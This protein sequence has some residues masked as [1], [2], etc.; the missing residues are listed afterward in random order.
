MK[1]FI[2]IILLSSVCFA[3]QLR[4]RVLNARNQQPL[5]KQTVT[6]QYLSEK[7]PSASSPLRLETDNR[8]EARFTLPNPVPTS[9]N[10]KVSLTSEHWHCGCWVM[11]DTAQVLRNGVAQPPSSKRAKKTETVRAEP[12]EVVILARPLTF[13]ERLLY[14][15]LKQ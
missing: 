12:G 9:V 11:A 1:A 2:W 8:G 10:I 5:E 7:P 4:V 3:Q 6:V 13:G 15:F 14:P